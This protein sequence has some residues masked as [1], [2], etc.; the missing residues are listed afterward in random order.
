MDSR[1][2]K[3][4]VREFETLVDLSHPNVVKVYDTGVFQSSPYLIMELIEGLTSRA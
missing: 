2:A 3:R 4:L 1:A